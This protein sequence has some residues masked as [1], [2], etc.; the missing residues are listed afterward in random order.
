MAVGFSTDVTFS[1]VP[2][3][4]ARLPFPAP[5]TDSDAKTYDASILLGSQADYDL[6]EA[7]VSGF[8]ILPAM[9]GGGLVVVKR[10]RGVRTL[11]IPLANGAERAYRALLVSLSPRVRMFSD[12]HFAADAS[13]L[14][15]GV[16]E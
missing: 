16:D 5:T 1:V 13:W 7:Y 15:L 8:D 3:D 10:G 11:T 9:G 6:L 12:D 2:D 4:G 14:V